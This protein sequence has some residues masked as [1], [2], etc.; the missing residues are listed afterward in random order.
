VQALPWRYGKGSQ[1]YVLGFAS[2]KP[3]KKVRR[4]RRAKME[5]RGG[6]REEGRYLDYGRAVTNRSKLDTSISTL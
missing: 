3:R 5:G 6:G 2:Y 4:G 1:K